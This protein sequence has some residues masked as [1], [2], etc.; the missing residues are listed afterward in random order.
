MC[1]EGCT[2]VHVCRGK[3]STLA[4][5]PRDRPLSALLFDTETLDLPIRL[6]WPGYEP[7]C[8][9]CVSLSSPGIPGTA[10]CLAL[11]V[12]SGV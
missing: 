11:Y 12:S 3:R 9:S 10:S 4:V 1:V 7:Q 6:G 5:V 8:A 2:Y